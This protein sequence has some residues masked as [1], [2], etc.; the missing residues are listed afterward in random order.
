MNAI[1][2]SQL[3]I[4]AVLSNM[5]FIGGIEVGMLIMERTYFEIGFLPYVLLS[6]CCYC[7]YHTSELIWRW[8]RE[9]EKEDEKEE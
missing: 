1:A 7:L 8:E 6:F 5:I 4:L 9:C 2:G 3:Y